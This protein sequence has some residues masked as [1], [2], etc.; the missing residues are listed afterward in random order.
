MAL[1]TCQTC[2]RPGSRSFYRG[3]RLADDRCQCGGKLRRFKH[4]KDRYREHTE[5]PKCW[6]PLAGLD[7][8]IKQSH[9]WGSSSFSSEG[10]EHRYYD[11]RGYKCSACGHE[12]SVHE[13][14]RLELERKSDA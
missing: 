13:K 8:G 1:V 9:V 7:Q 2:S 6:P 10:V 4:G 3:Y 12:W 11:L 5:C 14:Y